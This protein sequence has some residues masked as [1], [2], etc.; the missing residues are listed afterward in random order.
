MTAAPFFGLP[1]AAPA[2]P[3]SSPNLP[4]APSV[5]PGDSSDEQPVV[6]AAN[7]A[8]TGRAPPHQLS[9]SLDRSQLISGGLYSL[10]PVQ[11]GFPS[12]A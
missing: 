8:A 12:P 10:C 1:P 7:A 9:P 4:D 3:A 5:L 2:A 11:A 6:A